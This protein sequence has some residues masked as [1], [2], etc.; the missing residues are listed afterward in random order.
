[1]DIQDFIENGGQQFIP[2]LSI[3]LVIFGFQGGAL[4]C[5]LL[6][7]G[8]KW[9]LPGGHIPNEV[10]VDDAAKDILKMRTGLDQAHLKFLSVFGD[11]NRQFSQTFKEFLESRGL[12]WREDYWLN[13]RFVTVVYYSLVNIARTHPSV[14]N[15]DEAF[16]W[17]DFAELPAMWM[18]HK[19]IALDA[20]RRLKEDIKQELMTF[21]LLPDTFTMPE[22]HLLHQTI[23][24]EKIDRSRFQKKMVA[25][26]MFERLPKLAKGTPGRQP[27]QYR[28]KGYKEVSV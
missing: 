28:F 26:G 12:S 8:D 13:N 7:V 19:D 6:R 14:Q 10:S 22:L 11:R 1:M 25:T 24:E 21:N 3:D 17:I 2:N 9:L 18:D 23:L 20:R 5:L 27:Y 16:A 15:F 4:K